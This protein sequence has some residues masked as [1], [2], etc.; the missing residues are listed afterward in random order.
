MG[1][2]L[3]KTWFQQAWHHTYCTVILYTPGSTDK[4]I[5]PFIYHPPIQPANYLPNF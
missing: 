3:H 5:Y 1:G 4:L 2:A